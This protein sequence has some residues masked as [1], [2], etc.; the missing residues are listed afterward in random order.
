[1][2]EV[3]G[4]GNFVANVVWQKK[5]AVAN[6][7]KTIAPMHDHILIYRKSSVWLRNLLHREES[8]DRLY[9]FNDD[10]GMWRPDNYTCSKTVEERPNLYYPVKHPK[11]GEDIL[12]KRTRVW[13][14]SREQHA[15]HVAEHMIYWGKDGDARVP[16]IKRYKHLLRHDGTVPQ[17]L[18]THE[19]AG[20]TDTS[21]KETR[22]VLG[23]ESLADDFLTPKP[24]MLMSRVLEIASHSGDLIL[25]S[26]LGSGTTAAV[27]Q[28]MGR[29]WIGIEMGEH[30]K[31]H[32]LPRL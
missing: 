1:M 22:A 24:E 20:H 25:D 30:A 5:Y 26:F 31:T 9:R 14:F 19:F 2:D 12:P 17:S 8:K 28:K 7:H 11:T 27:A 4:R 23:T 3:F 16:S 29:R 15:L 6:D 10:R 13:A 21:R 18:W 32:C